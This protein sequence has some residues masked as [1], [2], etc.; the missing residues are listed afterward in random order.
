M[1]KSKRGWKTLA[2]GLLLTAV[3]TGCDGKE[4]KTSK[5]AEFNLFTEYYPNVKM[6]Y[7]YLDNYNG[8][9]VTALTS[10]EAPDIFFTYPWM[11]NQKEYATVFR[12]CP[13]IRQPMA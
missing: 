2:I 4:G 1:K 11:A 13:S 7:T 12:R 10:E 9:I 3:L 8:I 5:E 6:K